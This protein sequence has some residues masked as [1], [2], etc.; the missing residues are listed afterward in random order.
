MPSNTIV[1]IRD[2][3]LFV[4]A[5]HTRFFIFITLQKPV[6]PLRYCNT[7]VFC[8]LFI[9][10]TSNRVVFGIRMRTYKSCHACSQPYGDNTRVY[11]YIIHHKQVYVTCRPLNTH[12]KKRNT[13]YTRESYGIYTGIGTV[14]T[15]TRKKKLYFIR[16]DGK[17]VRPR[18]NDARG[19]AQR[20]ERSARVSRV[21]KRTHT[22]TIVR[23]II[24]CAQTVRMIHTVF[25]SKLNRSCAV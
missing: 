8:R 7:R 6:T 16:K 10:Y 9:V 1:L 22:S 18:V 14:H 5:A 24:R 19:S 3:I 13:F 4:L 25:L 2:F 12:S 21:Y 17:R 15:H 11:K 20:D 23:C